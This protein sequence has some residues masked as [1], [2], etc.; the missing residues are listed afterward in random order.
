[1]SLFKTLIIKNQKSVNYL[2]TN[3]KFS[4][5][6][7]NFDFNLNQNESPLLFSYTSL[8]ILTKTLENKTL[9]DIS[10]S[11]VHFQ[12]TQLLVIFKNN[13]IELLNLEV[14]ETNRVW[15][16]F[17]SIWNRDDSFVLVNRIRKIKYKKI[18]MTFELRRINKSFLITLMDGLETNNEAKLDTLT[19]LARRRS[20]NIED[21][22]DYHLR[23]LNKFGRF[24]KLKLEF[25]YQEFSKRF[26]F[27]MPLIVVEELIIKLDVK[28][29]QTALLL[30]VR[31]K[32][33]K[34]NLVMHSVKDISILYPHFNATRGEASR[35][36][37]ISRG[38]AMHIIPIQGLKYLMTTKSKPIARDIIHEY[39][40]NKIK[41]ALQIEEKKYL[42]RLYYDLDVV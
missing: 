23:N 10:F 19:L 13:D 9:G 16:E 38:T 25:S 3:I 4:P 28:Y 21:Q 20:E 33:K 40:S 32:A 30:L 42:K 39:S 7:L 29:H 41:P 31:H 11:F 12:D 17:L 8:N 37:S 22:F 6:Y 27:Q 14:L 2:A 1:M 15:N 26:T 36:I 5:K 35:D 34:V 18:R 24:Q